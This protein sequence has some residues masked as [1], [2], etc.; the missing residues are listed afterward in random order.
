MCIKTKVCYSYNPP[1][2][3][4]EIDTMLGL[5]SLITIGERLLK[6]EYVRF[7]QFLNCFLTDKYYM[8]LVLRVEFAF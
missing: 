6:T 4:D 3:R 2:L 7:L 5:Q 8:K 1:K